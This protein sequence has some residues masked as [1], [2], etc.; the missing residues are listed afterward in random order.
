LTAIA[1]NDS[2]ADLQNVDLEFL[3][4]CQEPS[5]STDL[6]GNYSPPGRRNG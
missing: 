4:L 6:R 5:K 1:D 3:L 2:S